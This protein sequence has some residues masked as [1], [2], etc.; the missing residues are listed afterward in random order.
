MLGRQKLSRHILALRDSQKFTLSSFICKSEFNWGLLSLKEV[1]Q[2]FKENPEER[3]EILLQS[4]G[5]HKAEAAV[6]VLPYSC[7]H[8]RKIPDMLLRVAAMTLLMGKGK[9]KWDTLKGKSGSFQREEKWHLSC[10][11]VL[12]GSPKEV[13]RIPP[14]STS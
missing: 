2:E 4:R 8:A 7:D 11:L 12:L 1:Y 10:C 6:E 9:G 5:C 13:S 14:K 3:R